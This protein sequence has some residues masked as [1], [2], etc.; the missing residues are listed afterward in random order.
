MDKAACSRSGI[1]A[2]A[3]HYFH[4]PKLLSQPPSLALRFKQAENVIF[5]DCREISIPPRNLVACVCTWALDV[6]YDA[7]GRV[8]HELNA[9]LGNT[10][11]GA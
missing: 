10:A 6:P 11:S 3:S 1:I 5:A 9:A 7:S 4:H 2:H 8:V